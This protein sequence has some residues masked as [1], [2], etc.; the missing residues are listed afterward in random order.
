[1]VDLLVSFYIK[2]NGIENMWREIGMAYYEW[3][4]SSE[5]DEYGLGSGNIICWRTPNALFRY[6]KLRFSGKLT[7][8]GSILCW[9]VYFVIKWSYQGLF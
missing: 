2:N 3:N 1:M 5:F 9:Y 8:D 6:E 4:G 7:L